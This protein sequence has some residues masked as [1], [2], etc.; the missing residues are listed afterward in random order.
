MVEEEAVQGGAVP[1]SVYAEY[2]NA[3]GGACHLG[4]SVF[5]M[6]TGSI[7]LALSNVWLSAWADKKVQIERRVSLAVYAALGLAHV[8]VAVTSYL[9][10]SSGAVK[11]ARHF[12]S[13]LLRSILE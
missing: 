13:S 10:V 3:A 4:F 5:L 2:L 12:H 8:T 11:A 1:F 7:L 9:R 6:L